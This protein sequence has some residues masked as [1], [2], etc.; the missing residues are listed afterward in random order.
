LHPLFLIC[1]A[2]LT[3]AL[4]VYRFFP[5]NL[6]VNIFGRSF[7][8]VLIVSLFMNFLV[9]PE[10]FNY[11]SGMKAAS[12]LK[13]N[14][15]SEPVYTFS[16]LIPE[17]AF[18]FYSAQPVYLIKQSELYTLKGNIR[19]FAPKIKIDSLRNEGFIIQDTL[20]FP[21]FHISKLNGTFLDSRTRARA[22]DSS[23]L[24]T[25]LPKGI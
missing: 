20:S 2:L 4:V 7:L 3:V 12:F 21:H 8:A 18:E 14:N 24:A 1:L 9:Y 22:I 25:I 15:Q 11:Q 13:K 19:V 5:G 10:I 6:L 16:E 17:F 23:M